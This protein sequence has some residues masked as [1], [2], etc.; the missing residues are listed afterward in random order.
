M[1]QQWLDVRI[2]I[3]AR[4]STTKNGESAPIPLHPRDLEAIK[5]LHHEAAKLHEGFHCRVPK[6]ERLRKDLEAAGI[7]Y[8]DERGRVFDFHALR[9]TFGTWMAVSGATPRETMEAMRHN[10]MR[11]TTQTYTDAGH[12]ALREVVRESHTGASRTTEFTGRNTANVQMP[13]LHGAFEVSV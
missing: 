13:G 7:P 1:K 4:A 6:M 10:D 8:R 12:L 2:A 11:L 9:V 3:Y 5:G